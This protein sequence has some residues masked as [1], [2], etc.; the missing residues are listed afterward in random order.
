MILGGKFPGKNISLRS[1]IG[2][3]SFFRVGYLSFLGVVNV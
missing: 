2:K 1:P 3:T